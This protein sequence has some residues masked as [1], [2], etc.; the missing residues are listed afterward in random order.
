MSIAAPHADQQ[1]EV[2]LPDKLPT[3]EQATGGTTRPA[4]PPGQVLRQGN[5]PNGPKLGQQWAKLSH[6]G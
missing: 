2:T 4:A 6:M 1:A 5:R 3:L